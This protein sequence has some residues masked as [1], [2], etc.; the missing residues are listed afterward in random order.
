MAAIKS[1]NTTKPICTGCTKEFT[2]ETLD[3]YGGICGRCYAKKI[4][5]T[6]QP[7]TLMPAPK[8]MPTLQTISMPTPMMPIS[9]KPAP[10]TPTQYELP[11][12][13]LRL[14]QISFDETK[15]LTQR[16]DNWYKSAK[17]NI[18]KNNAAIDVVYILVKSH[19]GNLDKIPNHGTLNFEKMFSLIHRALI[20]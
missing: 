6:A 2:K 20:E 9:I 7:V 10:N 1:S 3:K 15:T 11:S 16:L 18:P 14:S 5:A 13:M 19:I 17:N 12:E 8:I 4:E